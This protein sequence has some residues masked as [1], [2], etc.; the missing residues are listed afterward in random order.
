[1]DTTSSSDEISAFYYR[2]VNYRKAIAEVRACFDDSL[3]LRLEEVK[4]AYDHR[5]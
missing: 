1:M 4:A 2:I 5:L 3:Q